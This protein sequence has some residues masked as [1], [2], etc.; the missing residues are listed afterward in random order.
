MLSLQN[1]GWLLPALGW[2]FSMN[3]LLGLFRG[4][5]GFM[6]R[7]MVLGPLQDLR[8]LSEDGRLRGGRML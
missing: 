5:V 3:W 7:N 2:K 1:L 4:P 8:W 6:P